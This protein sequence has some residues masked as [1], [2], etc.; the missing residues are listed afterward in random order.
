MSEQLPIGHSPE[1]FQ[2]YAEIDYCYSMLELMHK[3]MAKDEAR[4]MI[5]KMV[6]DATGFAK[7]V[8]LKKAKAMR[9]FLT[10]IIRN[11][12][13]IQ[14]DTSKT[15]ATLALVEAIIKTPQQ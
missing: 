8:E 1:V 6:D 2:A 14:A 12:K 5:E 4:S 10:T 13:I 11:K 15:E 9:D 7:E 3:D